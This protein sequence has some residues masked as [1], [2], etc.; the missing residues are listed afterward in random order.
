MPDSN[1]KEQTGRG[2]EDRGVRVFSASPEAYEEFV[3]RLAAPPQPNDRLR[4][5][6]ATKAPWDAPELPAGAAR[7]NYR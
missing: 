2:A 3:V 4:R 6:L 5:T 1:I 7:H